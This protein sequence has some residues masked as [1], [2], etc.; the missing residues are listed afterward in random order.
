MNNIL[1][2]YF[3]RIKTLANENSVEYFIYERDAA[4]VM[5][6]SIHLKF[7]DKDGIQRNSWGNGKDKDEAFGKAL[8]EMI[9]RIYFS[10][11]S[12]FTFKNLFGI[13]KKK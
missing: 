12:P 3:E 6:F 8:M 10:G 9:E 13:L 2:Q 5:P 7:T 4:T 1:L 11:L